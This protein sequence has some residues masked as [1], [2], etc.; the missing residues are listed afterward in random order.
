[1]T[2]KVKL[3]DRNNYGKKRPT[4]SISYIVMHYTAN[5]GDSDEAN[6]NY[7][8]NNVVKTSA[9][10]FVDSDSITQSVP[11]DYIAY[12][13]GAN[14]YVHPKCR[15]GNSIGIELCDDQKNGR[16]DFTDSELEIAS[17]L[18][19][20]LM[21]KY[22]VPAESVI[23]HYDVTG[24]K[25]PAPFVDDARAWI[26]FKSRLEEEEV[27][28]EQFNSMMDAWLESKAKQAPGKWSEA[29]R[30]WAES[31]GL[32]QGDSSNQKRYKSFATREEMAAM[33]HRAIEK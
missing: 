27:T 2:I 31:R 28:Q 19:K 8:A 23:R 4:S 22:G 32:V 21:R 18:V 30:E 24:K 6:G 20:S 15:N 7:F 12:H 16:Y 14:K 5:D 9:H 29:D 1:M 17:N 10:Y 3:A 13:C 26:N 11:D 33:L 25:C